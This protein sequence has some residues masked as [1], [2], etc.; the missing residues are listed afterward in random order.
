MKSGKLLHPITIANALDDEA[1]FEQLSGELESRLGAASHD[2]DAMYRELL[3][4]PIGLRAMG[5][6]HPLDVSMALEDLGWHF[7]RWPSQLLANETLAG[8]KLLGAS[9]AAETFEVALLAALEHWSFICS[10][11]FFDRYDDSALAQVLAPLNQRLWAIL[12]YDG[13]SGKNLMEYWVPYARLNPK[14]VC[15]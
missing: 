12:G 1:I 9:E 14:D 15:R 7:G 4:L 11:E 10:G 6:V 2:A 5:S 13:S 8:L 3:K